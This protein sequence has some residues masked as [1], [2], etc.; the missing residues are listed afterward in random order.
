MPRLRTAGAL[1]LLAA[2]GDGLGTAAE[3]NLTFFD[4]DFNFDDSPGR[5]VATVGISF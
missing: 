5:F 4:Q 3:S 2:L 1:A